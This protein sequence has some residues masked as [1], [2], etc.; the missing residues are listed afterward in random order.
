MKGIKNHIQGSWD[1]QVTKD[2]IEMAMY[3]VGLLAVLYF[4][5]QIKNGSVDGLSP[6][7]LAGLGTFLGAYSAFYLQNQHAKKVEAQANINEINHYLVLLLTK[8]DV[9]YAY[10]NGHTTEPSVAKEPIWALITPAP[11][12]MS[13]PRI[14]EL[15]VPNCLVSYRPEILQTASKQGSD[16]SGFIQL[17]N[18]F[19]KSCTEQIDPLL[20]KTGVFLFPD[21]LHKI[22]KQLQLEAADYSRLIGSAESLIDLL[23]ASIVT[24]NNARDEILKIVQFLYPNT[25][26]AA[27]TTVYKQRSN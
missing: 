10:K 7:I 25:K 17:A 22:D 13:D 1:Q 9:L 6:I 12:L 15:P 2:L 24:S 8:I 26:F 23:N 4:G 14:A 18:S 27:K 5:Y 3:F 21:E 19:Y 20:N 11:F 16:F